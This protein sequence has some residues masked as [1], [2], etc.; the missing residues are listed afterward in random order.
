MTWSQVTAAALGGFFVA[1]VGMVMLIEVLPFPAIDRAVVGGVS[2]PA[3]WVTSIVA[4]CLRDGGRS[5]WRLQGML[6]GGMALIALVGLM[7]R[8]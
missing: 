8:G 7:A 2:F 4:A 6:L 3:L 5:A 1:M